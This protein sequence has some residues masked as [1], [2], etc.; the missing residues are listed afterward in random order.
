ME[1]VA[2]SRPTAQ[3]V[4]NRINRR[5]EKLYRKVDNGYQPY[6]CLICDEFLKPNELQ[7]LAVTT[8]KRTSNLLKPA[9]WLGLSVGLAQCYKYGGDIGTYND[10][11]PEDESLRCD[12]SEMLLSPR[13]CYIRAES[14][15]ECSGF[16]CCSTCKYSLQHQRLP[17]NAIANNYCF[18]TPPQCLQ[19]LTDLE[20]ALLTPVKTHGYCFSYTGGAQKQLKGSLSYYKVNMESI[21]RA[22]LH[23]DVLGL[24]NNIVVLLYGQMTPE[25]RKRAQQKSK[26]RTDYILSIRGGGILTW[27]FKI[28]LCFKIILEFHQKCFKTRFYF[29]NFVISKSQNFSLSTFLNSRIT[30][31]LK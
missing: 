2:T 16:S 5:F 29:R 12:I 13:A 10:S 17:G 27:M 1:E 18:G 28:K 7:R 30:V 15:N 9:Q 26:I 23:F 3:E 21:A 25:Q 6:V 24:T 20:L 22:A 19:D 31:I 8:L 4:S 14:R 11:R